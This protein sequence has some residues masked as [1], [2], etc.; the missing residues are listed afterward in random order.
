MPLPRPPGD[1][2]TKA[3]IPIRATEVGQGFPFRLYVYETTS[4]IMKLETAITMA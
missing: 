4:T 1:L 2:I 3:L